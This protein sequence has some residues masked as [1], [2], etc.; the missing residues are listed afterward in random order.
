[1]TLNYSSKYWDDISEG[2]KLSKTSMHVPFEKV[3]LD[4]AATQ[5]YFPGH[6]NP[7]YARGQ[8]QRDIYLN[9]MAIEGFI[10]RLATDWAGPHA[11]I[12]QRKMQMRASIYSG[13]TM[14]G[15]GQVEKCYEDEAGR[16]L[17]DISL[18]I[19]T[20]EGPRVPASLT[21]EIPRKPA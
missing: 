12:R 21:L 18:T 2:D 17:V 5:D 3:I 4:A 11:F 8:G 20:H 7:E 14:S 13:D 9:T 10:D 6:H 15:E 19:S 1:M 16:A